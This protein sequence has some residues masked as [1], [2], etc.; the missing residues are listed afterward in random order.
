[1]NQEN[2]KLD[3]SALSWSQILELFSCTRCGACV[4]WCPVYFF[5]KKEDITPRAKLAAVRKIFRSNNS[6]L[7][8]IFKPES[9]I[10]KILCPEIPEEEIKKTAMALYECSTCRQC[11]FVC[12]SRIDT[13][14]LYEALRKVFVNA[15][16]GPL[17]NHAALISSSKDYDNPWKQPRSH[18]ARWTKVAKKEGRIS[19]TP[20]M[21]KPPAGLEP[22]RPP[23]KSGESI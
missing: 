7:R 6:L 4:K 9:R 12:P 20:R 8:R 10:A 3:F 11:H 16:Y 15:G 17:P 2:R 23:K 21:I 1:M 5:D 19:E 13:V 22:P 18:R 14:E